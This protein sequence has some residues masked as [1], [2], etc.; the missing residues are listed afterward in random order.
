MIFPFFSLNDI[1]L[2]MAIRMNQNPTT[3]EVLYRWSIPEYLQY[4]RKPVWYIAMIVIGLFFVL[5]GLFTGNFLFSLI[6]ILFA[7]IIFIQSHQEPPLIPFQIT[8]LG[9]IISDRFYPYSELDSFYIVYDPPAVKTLF[10][11]TNSF[12][13]PLLRIPLED[14]NPVEIRHVLQEF[15]DEDLDKEDEPISDKVARGLGLH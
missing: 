11:E 4:E 14:Q 7:I 13:H 12:Y 8:E 15:L 6:I 9:I 1:L 10:F 3:G 5:F 2:Y